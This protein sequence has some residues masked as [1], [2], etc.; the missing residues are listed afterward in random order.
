MYSRLEQSGG[1]RTH[2]ELAGESCVPCCKCSTAAHAYLHSL[3]PLDY[4]NCHRALGPPSKHISP[5]SKSFF[6]KRAQTNSNF[7]TSVR[8]LLTVESHQL[9]VNATIGVAFFLYA[10]TSERDP[11][12]KAYVKI[13]N[14]QSVDRD[15]ED[16][17]V[18]DHRRDPNIDNLFLFDHGLSPTIATGKEP[19]SSGTTA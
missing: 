16:C 14:S 7:R 2:F 11:D 10:Y 3:S 1:S 17:S 18:P 6:E 19:I 15:L 8:K 13:V 5:N 9:V 12:V 4:R